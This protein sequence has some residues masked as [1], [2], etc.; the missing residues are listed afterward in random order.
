MSAAK[1][2]SKRNATVQQPKPWGLIF[3]F[4]G[5]GVLALAIIL[6]SVYIV[7][8]SGEAPEGTVSFYDDYEGGTELR[9]AL[10]AGDV[11]AED[12]S[13]PQV[14]QRT[15]IDPGTYVDYGQYPPVG[16]DHYPQWQQ[17]NG[18]V[19]NGA[20]DNRHAVHSLEHGAVWVTY[21]PEELSED[22]VSTL[23]VKVDG[24]D[25]TMMSQYPD[26]GSPVSV[27]AWGFQ[28]TVDS[29]DD[30]RI[31]EFMDRFAR[32]SDNTMEPGAVCS[33]GNKTVVDQPQPDPPEEDGESD[34]EADNSEEN[35]SADD[36]S[37]EE[38]NA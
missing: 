25:A 32:A 37:E 34:D 33:R 36:A 38:D 16:G 9:K 3:T 26:Q 18:V 22:D 11:E 8:D 20:I 10:E 5:V 30:E 1:N 19:Y 14:A 23:A 29:A 6:G 35:E 13:H 24:R 27:Q 15:H 28:L 2:K 21:D 31:E 12:L 7:R 17:C 4:V